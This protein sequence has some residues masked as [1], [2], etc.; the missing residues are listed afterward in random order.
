MGFIVPTMNR[1]VGLVAAFDPE[2][3]LTELESDVGLE[4]LGLVL[5]AIAGQMGVEVGP[6]RAAGA[7]LER[8][9]SV[10]GGEA[11]VVLGQAL[12]GQVPGLANI[13]MVGIVVELDD[14]NAVRAGLGNV[15]SPN[16]E[17]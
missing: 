17:V 16:D 11:G 14:V 5:R 13:E 4:D 9:S 2:A 6:K 1:D 12:L 10:E 15:L 3:L 8:P 7:A